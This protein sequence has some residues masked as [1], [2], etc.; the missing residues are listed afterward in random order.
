MPLQ[1]SE[2]NSEYFLRAVRLLRFLKDKEG[3]GFGSKTVGSVF[4]EQEE[5][6]SRIAE[7]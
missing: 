7:G 4:E 2:E 6:S 3:D 5:N 1:T